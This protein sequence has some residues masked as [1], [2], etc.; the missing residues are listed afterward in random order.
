M[1]RR[2]E[3]DWLERKRQWEYRNRNPA[4]SPPPPPPAIN[5]SPRR[6]RGGSGG[7]GGG[8]A[9]SS[10]DT[11][12]TPT[13]RGILSPNTGGSGGNTR[14]PTTTTNTATLQ[15]RHTAGNIMTDTN[16]LRLLSSGAQGG[17]YTEEVPRGIMDPN[18]FGRGGHIRVSD[19]HPASGPNSPVRG[20]GAFGRGGG[21]GGGGGGEFKVR[22]IVMQ[23]GVVGTGA[24]GGGGGA[25]GVARGRGKLWEP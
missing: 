3:V 19:T 21:G 22:G 8:G 23:R 17:S 1:V 11:P 15:R 9:G 10:S 14:T 13:I 25:R 7:G 5:G 6:G 20:R 16:P 2:E 12:S 18:G 24:G 4:G